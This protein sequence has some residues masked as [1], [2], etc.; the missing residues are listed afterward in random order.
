MEPYE[1][2][3]ADFVTVMGHN[4]STRVYATQVQ[5]ISSQLWSA[6]LFCR[7]ALCNVKGELDATGFEKVIRKQLQL[8]IQVV[9]KPNN[10]VSLKIVSSFE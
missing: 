3:A 5:L 7:Q 10:T 9:V 2:D 8:F 1:T 4:W 6:Y